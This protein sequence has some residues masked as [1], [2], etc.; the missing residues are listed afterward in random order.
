MTTHADKTQ[1]DKSQYFSN[2]KS[3]TLTADEP[4]FQFVD[5]RMEA[6]AQ[7]KLQKMANNSAH[8]SQLKALNE[9]KVNGIIP[10]SIYA[11]YA[12][13]GKKFLI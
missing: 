8:V 11:R 2:A 12:F 9:I 1:E 4:T 10:F 3:N 13:I 6:V 5:N 7:R